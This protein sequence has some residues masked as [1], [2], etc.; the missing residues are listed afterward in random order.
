MYEEIIANLKAAESDPAAQADQ[1]T[2][3]ATIQRYY[4]QG[5]LVE[6]HSH[7]NAEG[8]TFTIQRTYIAPDGTPIISKVHSDGTVEDWRAIIITE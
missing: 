7:D 8:R 1:A 6:V 4:D 3:M 2:T 5:L